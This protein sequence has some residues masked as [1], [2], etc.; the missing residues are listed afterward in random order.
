MRW[1]PAAA[2][3][4]IRWALAGALLALLLA[5]PRAGAQSVAEI[6]ITPDTM[7]LAVG[8]QR[9][10]LAAAFDGQGN[11]L[12]S[13][14]F[15]FWS[16]D[17]L[18]AS[19]APD[20]TVSG[21]HPGLAKIEARAQGRRAALALLVIASSTPAEPVATPAS[22]ADTLTH[23]S[24][25]NAVVLA[26][27]P[28]AATLL[29]GESLQLAPR[30]LRGDGSPADPVRVAWRSFQPSVATIDSSGR[31]TG[32]AP[33]TALVEARSAGG[34][35][36]TAQ[37]TVS[38]AAFVIPVTRLVLG[39]SERDTLRAII[40]S[41]GGRQLQSGLTWTVVDS[42]IARA[43][44]DGVIEGRYS[45]TTE[46]VVTGYGQAQ[47]IPIRVHRAAASFVVSPRLGTPI[48][49]PVRGTHAFRA[50]AEAADSTPIPEAHITWSVGD[51][52][53][54]VLDT[55]SG[56]LTGRALGNTTI[57]ARLAGFPP[58][59]WNVTVVP[60]KIGVDPAR[61]ALRLGSRDTLTAHLLDQSGKPSGTAP[62]LTWSS[63]NPS[64]ALVGN[65]GVVVAGGLGHSVITAT[66][67]WGQQAHADLYVTGDLLLSSNRGGNFDLYT[68]RLAA[69]GTF[70][71]VMR[72]SAADIDGVFSPDHTRIAFSSN[73]IGTFAIYLM[74]ADGSDLRR[75]TLGTGGDG[76]PAWSPDGT[77]LAY[78]SGRSGTRQIW[79]MTA[80]GNN[81]HALTDAPKESTA[82]AFSPDGSHIAFISARDG[83]SELYLMNADGSNQ[84]RLTSTPG[85]EALPQFFPSGDLAYV[86]ARPRGTGSRI[87]R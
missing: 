2:T 4:R 76:E 49:L 13:A 63:S 19:V 57:T 38:P 21:R 34:L 86:T 26:V 46:L 39:P 67:P 81:P 32:V 35:A 20:G 1:T 85:P 12:P 47:R 54:A 41:Q 31:V 48:I 45:G 27:D 80:D 83:N 18:V 79:L 44:Q 84:Q 64:V 51:T 75:I 52:T 11:L 17:T 14:R 10:V 29:P 22:T 37:I 60:G 50:S 24:A 58:A 25:A 68:L 23:A 73:R 9:T 15:T 36:G 3:S 61:L 74:N 8:H 7:T 56:L 55:I 28:P 53:L 40:P 42:G 33:G 6:Q 43:Y 77:Q 66:A 16:S 78:T 71:P 30:P 5:P 82:P 69:P 72:D 62:D 70:L 87:V 65:D 59:T